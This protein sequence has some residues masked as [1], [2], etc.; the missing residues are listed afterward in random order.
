[1]D[2]SDPD[3]PKASVFL[4]NSELFIKAETAK[5]A[6]FLMSSAKKGFSESILPRGVL[7][8]EYMNLSGVGR[9]E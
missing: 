8:V 6:N 9:E 1:M 4:A 5:G 2:E 7:F 3:I